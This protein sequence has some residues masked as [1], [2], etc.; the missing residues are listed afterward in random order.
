[1]VLYEQQKKEQLTINDAAK[2]WS[3]VELPN[4]DTE[5]VAS[6]KIAGVD[7]DVSHI[8]ATLTVSD[9][10]IEGRHEPTLLIEAADWYNP[11]KDE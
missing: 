5:F 6:I 10:S 11:P 3:R 2:G 9:W 1:M 4:G 8:D 7:L